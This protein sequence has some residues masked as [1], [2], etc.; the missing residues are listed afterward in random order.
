PSAPARIG[1]IERDRREDRQR[2]LGRG[3][4]GVAVVLALLDRLDDQ[5]LAPPGPHPTP[6][7]VAGGRDHRPVHGRPPGGARR[8]ARPP[9]LT[10]RTRP[11]QAYLQRYERSCV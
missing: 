10:L 9:R 5:A 3:D 4:E 6:G 2:L 8:P 7:G 11:G 1:A